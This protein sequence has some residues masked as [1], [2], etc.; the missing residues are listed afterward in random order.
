[1]LKTSPDISYILAAA[2]FAFAI[3]AARQLNDP[4]R[5]RFRWQF[6]S[7]LVRDVGIA[8][9]FGAMAAMFAAA[10]PPVAGIALVLALLVSWLVLSTYFSRRASD[11][12]RAHVEAILSGKY[13]RGGRR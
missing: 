10:I 13:D 6:A 8:L 4:D 2:A 11:E 9:L 7:G 1:M 3:L 12:G 5:R